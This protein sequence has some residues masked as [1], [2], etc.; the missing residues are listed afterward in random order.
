[1][2]GLTLLSIRL[3]VFALDAYAR[4]ANLYSPEQGDDA[5]PE[6]RKIRW[7]VMIGYLAAILIGLAYPEVAVALYFALTLFLVIPARNVRRRVSVS[8][9]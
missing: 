8:A 6:G 4:S 1:V 2:Y 9:R 3:L 7:P 5:E